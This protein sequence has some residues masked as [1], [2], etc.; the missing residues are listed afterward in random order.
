MANQKVVVRTGDKV[1]KSGIY[2]RVGEK[3][4]EVLSTGDRVPPHKA[5]KQQ[6]VLVRE[7]KHTRERQ[8]C[9][10]FL[11]QLLLEYSKFCQPRHYQ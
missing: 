6:L 3:N 9:F 1:E 11:R 5:S 10:F 7:A 4:E 8:S 2:R